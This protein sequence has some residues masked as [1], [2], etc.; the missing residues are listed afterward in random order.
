MPTTIQA[1]PKRPQATIRIRA[2]AIVAALLLGPFATP[3][4]AQD[5]ASGAVDGAAT[6]LYA[7]DVAA[8]EA[9]LAGRLADAPG[10]LTARFA[11]GGVR[12]LAALEGLAQDVHRFGLGSGSVGEVRMLLPFEVPVNP[13]PAPVRYQDVRDAL[14]RFRTRLQG[15]DATLAPLGELAGTPA[16]ASLR[17][18]IELGRVR[19]DLDGDGVPGAPLATGL[20]ALRGGFATDAE[21]ADPAIAIDA[22]LGDALWLRGYLNLL[23]AVTDAVLAHDAQRLWDATAQLFFARA[24]TAYP[25]L[26]AP[27][28]PDLG[29]F[30][31]ALVADLIAMIHLIDLPVAEPERLERALAHL[32]T[33]AATSRASWTE[34]LAETDD[35]RE[36]LP[37]PAQTGVVPAGRGGPPVAVEAEML[38]AWF[39]MLDEVDA[40]LAGRTL[41]PYWRVADGRG[42]NLR[43]VFLEPGR[44][45]L[46]LWL[47][48]A[49]AA[50]YLEQGEVTDADTW[51]DIV[52]A[53]GGD[54]AAFAFWF[55]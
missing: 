15:A 41:V 5:A 29:G 19:L 3:A 49:A 48:G 36:W 10:D 44:F 24:E 42:L 38:D 33:T 31:A 39:V 14:E 8:A 13:V 4:S 11:L 46:V 54:F 34:I 22:D 51:R 52:R 55:N 27:S 37:N 18:R 25:Y 45:D 23:A 28:A 26:R 21:P 47:Q 1:R 17:W 53:F 43:R 20:D 12:T 35:G 7:G 30:D 2:V 50:P 40:I 32:E 9:L 6:S 16:A